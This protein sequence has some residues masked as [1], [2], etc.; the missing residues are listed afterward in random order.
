MSYIV[1]D[2]TVSTFLSKLD[3]LY[4]QEVPHEPSRPKQKMLEAETRRRAH[5]CKGCVHTRVGGWKKRGKGNLPTEL[6]PA[7]AAL[8]VMEAGTRV[9]SARAISSQ[10]WWWLSR[11]IV[12]VVASRPRCPVAHVYCRHHIT[13][14]T[15]HLDLY[16]RRPGPATHGRVAQQRGA[17]ASSQQL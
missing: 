17:Q 12:I 2:Y 5:A 8:L 14:V 7:P 10:R 16:T 11:R 13:H 3:Q 6:A 1:Y 4:T 9:G 15:E